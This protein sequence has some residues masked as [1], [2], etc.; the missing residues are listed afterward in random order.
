MKKDWFNICWLVVISTLLVVNIC[1]IFNIKLWDIF[2]ILS[3]LNLMF[4][5]RSVFLR[6][7]KEP[8]N[9]LKS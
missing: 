1:M 9:K 6:Y 5:T 2:I 3:M 4:L 8:K 7:R